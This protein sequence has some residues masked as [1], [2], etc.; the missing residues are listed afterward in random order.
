L[1][2]ALQAAGHIDRAL[3]LFEAT[4]ERQKDTLGA[5]HPDTLV[6]MRNLASVYESTRQFKKA[7][8]LY[9]FTLA[10]QQARFPDHPQTLALTTDLVVAYR[11]A[12]QPGKAMPLFLKLLE[13]R[14]ADLG[15]EARA[16]LQGQCFLASLYQ[17]DRQL[18]KAIALCEQTI[19]QQKR[20]FGPDDPDTLLTMNNLGLT[21]QQA[22]DM[23]KALPLFE[24]TLARRRATLGPDNADTLWSLGNLASAYQEDHQL[25]KALPLFE[26]TFQRRKAKSG[27]DSYDTLTSLTKLCNAYY[28]AGQPG[29]ALQ[30]GAEALEARKNKPGAD[31]E[32]ILRAMNDLAA[33]YWLKAGQL[34]KAI[35]LFEQTLKGRQTLP[36]LGPEHPFTLRTESNLA[37]AYEAND[38][39][40][41]AEPLWRDLLNHRRK[42]PGPESLVTAEALAA[43]GLNLLRQKKFNQAESELRL[44]LD[45]RTKNKLQD[46]S[47]ADARSMLGA[48]LAGQKKYTDAEPLLLD[49][50]EQ[51]K[52]RE[53]KVPPQNR[54]RVTDALQRA[55]QGLVNFYDA[56]AQFDKAGQWRKKLSKSGQTEGP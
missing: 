35:V 53:A 52:A 39:P 9:E 48:A 27:L 29:K 19:E 56:T 4:L 6:T 41:K 32:D 40:E 22:H 1:A 18:A 5:D 31:Q 45:L 54:E 12:G 25:D 20:A 14:R 24:L 47:T 2:A 21:Y 51:L 3:P 36:A 46:W 13:K 28:A 42:K 30:L 15:P 37:L 16:T 34:D 49:G 33:G 17:E 50:Y 55:L 44:C 26:E 7:V 8:S 10:R 43:L 11:A 38:Q 23:I